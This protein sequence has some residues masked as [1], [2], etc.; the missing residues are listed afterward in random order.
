MR[1]I[2]QKLKNQSGFTYIFVIITFVVV[3]TIVVGML[4]LVDVN[5]SQAISQEDTI[6][7][8][9]L[10]VS[11]LELTFAALTVSP[12]HDE[13]NT[14][15]N[16]LYKTGS[17]DTREELED[18][19]M[20]TADGSSGTIQSSVDGSVTIRVFAFEQDGRRWVEIVSTATVADTGVT[21]TARLQFLVDNPLVQNNL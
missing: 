13:D 7:A 3:T 17:I 18:T 16:N 19:I 15:S 12:D 14:L 2:Y 11:G 20:F 9:Y 6:R 1:K 21:K 4:N 5:M 8:H 10:A